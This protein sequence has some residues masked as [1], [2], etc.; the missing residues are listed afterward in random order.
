[1]DKFILIYNYESRH[2]L[3]VYVGTVRM[4]KK[5]I[6]QEYGV[7]DKIFGDKEDSYELDSNNIDNY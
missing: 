6:L 2:E 4:I 5:F 1:M 7:S 3:Y